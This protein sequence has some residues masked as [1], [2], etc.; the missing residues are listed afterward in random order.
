MILLIVGL[1][2]WFVV[3][4]FPIFA[5]GPRGALKAK[6]GLGYT[7]A[8]ALISVGTIVLIVQGYGAAPFIE[9][10]SP[11]TFLIHVNNL[12]MVI[13]V[14]F[15][16]G[17]TFKSSPVLRWTRHPQLNGVKTWA[18][19]HLLVNGDLAS[20]L[21]FGGFLVWGVVAMIG[22]NKRD[23]KPVRELTST[24]MGL[25]LHLAA[26]AVVTIAVMMAHW[27]LGAVWPFAGSPP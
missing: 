2:T 9:V 22:S 27:Y 4:L 15:F 16:I 19:A 7:I 20:I 14:L 13:A 24:A 18:I 12:L 26:T 17:G 5:L 21:L 23:G 1:A 10:W 3:H 11:P 6:F 25:V 8:Y